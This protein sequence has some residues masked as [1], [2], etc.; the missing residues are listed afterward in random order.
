MKIFLISI[1]LTIIFS[2]CSFD[3]KTGIWQNANQEVSKKIDI[4]KDFETLNLEAESFKTVIK[5]KNNL[6]INLEPVLKNLKWTDEFYNPTNNLSNF[7][8]DDSDE[9]I[10]KSSRLTKN[11]SSDKILYDNQNLILSDDKG[12]IIFYSIE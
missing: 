6:K 1:L 10:F 2:G 5:P 7:S 11:K 3:N 8:Y 12:N 4:F 9:L